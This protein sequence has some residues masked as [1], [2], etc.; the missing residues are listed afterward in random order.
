MV[1]T[2][3]SSA[4]NVIQYFTKFIHN[5]EWGHKL[6]I[7]LSLRNRQCDPCVQRHVTYF[8]GNNI[9]KMRKELSHCTEQC[10]PS[11]VSLDARERSLDMSH[12]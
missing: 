4:S 5:D 9:I 10:E 3:Q 2:S 1:Q 6:E 8:V 7:S 11:I 12:L